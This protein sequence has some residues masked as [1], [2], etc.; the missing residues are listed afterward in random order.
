VKLY[1]FI[2]GCVSYDVTTEEKKNKHL[3]LLLKKTWDMQA[4]K[5]S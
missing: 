5:Q 1:C 3:L 4:S 2:N